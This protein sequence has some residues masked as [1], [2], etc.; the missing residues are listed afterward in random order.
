MAAMGS[1]KL[2]LLACNALLRELC[3]LV[4]RSPNIFDLDFNELDAH[5]HSESLRALIQHKIDAADGAG[6]DAIL[7][8]YGLCGNAT[9]G[10]RAGVTRLVIPRA[11]DCCTL[12]L[13]SRQ[14]FKRHFRDTP[15]QPFSSTGYGERATALFHEGLE[16]GP[17]DAVY[18][19]YVEKYG[20]ENARY[21]FE[22][23][24]APAH[25]Q[26]RLVFIDVSETAHLG[27]AERCEQRARADGREFL[28]LP[29]S[30]ELL[31]K[32]VDGEWDGDFLVL[33]PGQRLAGVYDWDE[34]VRAEPAD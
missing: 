22:A 26:N 12:L 32:L 30:L 13:G 18:R 28:R 3:Y 9:V 1:L 23:M 4:S 14:E 20:E 21:I 15:S 16:G 11:H 5:R 29:G 8:G 10:L 19:E 31:R 7:L 27:A 24:T 2:R 17:S 33:E 6:Y 25:T 34:I